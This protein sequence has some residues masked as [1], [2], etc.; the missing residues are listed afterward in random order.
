MAEIK[1]EDL[2][3]DAGL[4]RLTGETG[5]FIGGDSDLAAARDRYVAM[6][7]YGKGQATSEQIALLNDLDNVL[8]GATSRNAIATMAS[9]P[10]P[11]PIRQA[12]QVQPSAP[13]APAVGGGLA[14]LQ[15]IRSRS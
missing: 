1:I 9:P 10:P 8:A 15:R 13:V 4:R 14:A 5:V 3:E 6:Q 12:P 11:A 2:N 7:A